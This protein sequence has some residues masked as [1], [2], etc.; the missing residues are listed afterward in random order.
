MKIIKYQLATEINR[1]PPAKSVMEAVLSDK[2]G[3]N[4]RPLGF[5]FPF[6]F[7]WIAYTIPGRR[8]AEYLL[9]SNNAFHF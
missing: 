9:R 6:L 3:R 8:R 4:D 1:R 2:R 5:T 7:G